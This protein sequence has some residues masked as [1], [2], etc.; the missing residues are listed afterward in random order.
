MFS[1]RPMGRHFAMS[2]YRRRRTNIM[3]IL[4]SI[5]FFLSWLPLN[6]INTL[7]DFSPDFMSSHLNGQVRH[8]LNILWAGLPYY[9]AQNCFFRKSCL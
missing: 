8:H 5:F 3:I 2:F 1:T 4:I 6:V 9:Y 7:L